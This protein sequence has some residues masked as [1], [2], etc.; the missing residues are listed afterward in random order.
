MSQNKEKEAI[1]EL[2][3]KKITQQWMN[4]NPALLQDIY[5]LS[6]EI[7]GFNAKWGTKLDTKGLFN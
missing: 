1:K 5:D 7:V 3:L 6:A 2:L 4:D